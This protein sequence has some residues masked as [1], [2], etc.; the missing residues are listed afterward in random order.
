MPWWNPFST[1][2]NNGKTSEQLDAELAALD[3]QRAAKKEAEAQWFDDQGFNVLATQAR[4][5]QAAWQ[6]AHAANL[7]RQAEAQ[8][9]QTVGQ[10]FGEGWE[11][12]VANVRGAVDGAVKWT[13]GSVFGALPWYLWLAGLVFLLWKL[14]LFK[15]KAA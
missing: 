13:L 3:A 6:E 2:A 15:R 8:N 9:A 11:D 5:E 12:G 1:D 10:A 14:G 7:E 4:E